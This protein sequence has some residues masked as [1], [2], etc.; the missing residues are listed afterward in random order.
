MDIQ[1]IAAISAIALTITSFLVSSYAKRLTRFEIQLSDITVDGKRLVD[2]VKDSR[3]PEAKN[4]L[5]RQQ[6]LATR[7]RFADATLIFGQ[8][9]IGG[10]L[11]SSFIQ[12]SLNP[13]IIG[14]M[15]VLVLVSSLIRQR[16][17][18]DLQAAGARSR[19]A[20][21]RGLIRDTEDRIYALENGRENTMKIFEIREIVSKGL[22]AVEESELLDLRKNAGD[23]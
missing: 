19:V 3:L 8:Y 5:D 18:P 9:I 4:A 23:N 10:V 7:Y 22:K 2:P 1:N 12:Q 16:Y 13:Q 11:A 21:L 14:L 17:R 15:G 6:S 20:I